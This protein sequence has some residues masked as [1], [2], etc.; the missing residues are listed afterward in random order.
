VHYKLD[1]SGGLDEEQSLQT[2]I[3]RDLRTGV[4]KS[5][6]VDGGIFKHLLRT[7][8]NLSFKN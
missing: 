5:N 6:D 4:A 3:T 2:G 7:A 1:I 8:T